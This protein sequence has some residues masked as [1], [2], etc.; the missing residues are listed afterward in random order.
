M[1]ASTAVAAAGRSARNE[2]RVDAFGCPQKLLKREAGR[3]E[4]PCLRFENILTR[5]KIMVS[6]MPKLPGRG[7]VC[8]AGRPAGCTFHTD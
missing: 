5:P 7:L 3:A 8:H 4:R 6:N 1:L 2:G